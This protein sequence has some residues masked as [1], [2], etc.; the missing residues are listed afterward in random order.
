MTLCKVPHPLDL[1]SSINPAVPLVIWY[2]E[3]LTKDIMIYES[4]LRIIISL[5]F[6]EQIQN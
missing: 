3:F 1:V 2:H 6:N 5:Q 4:D